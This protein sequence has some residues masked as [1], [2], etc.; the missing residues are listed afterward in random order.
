[1]VVIAWV[2]AANEPATPV[3]CELDVGADGH[4]LV[5]EFKGAEHRRKVHPAFLLNLLPGQWRGAKYIYRKPIKLAASEVVPA[6]TC[7]QQEH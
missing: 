4:C 5:F 1:M 6:H 2:R 7:D 3:L